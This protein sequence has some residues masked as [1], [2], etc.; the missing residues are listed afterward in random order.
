MQS[1]SEGGGI[2]I[3]G[4]PHKQTREIRKAEKRHFTY[5]LVKNGGHI[6]PVPTPMIC[7]IQPSYEDPFYL[8]SVYSYTFQS[9]DLH[10]NLSDNSSMS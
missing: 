2:C 7:N 6:P 1:K 8:A 9:Q 4:C 3:M 10:G 5:K